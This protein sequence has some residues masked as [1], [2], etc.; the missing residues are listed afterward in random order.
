ME[1]MIH[2][3]SKGIERLSRFF[4]ILS[5][6]SMA[7][8]V[9]VVF[10]SVITRYIL[11]EPFHW[12]IEVTCWLFVSMVF[13]GAAELTRKGEQIHIDVILM[14]LSPRARKAVEL[15]ILFISLFWCA[16]IDWQ[17]WKMTVNA[18]RYG[19][20]SSSLLRFPLFIPYSFLSIGLA[21]LTLN[22]LILFGKNAAELYSPQGEVK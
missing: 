10:V 14:R 12:N 20:T 9:G 13:M 4:F 1:K 6:V 3:I 16:L 18:Y 5:E 8:I 21:V 2:F 19:M 17:A 11:N 22:L 7:L 15:L